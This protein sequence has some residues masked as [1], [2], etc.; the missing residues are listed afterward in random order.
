LQIVKRVGVLSAGKVFGA[1]YFC[2]GLLVIPMFFL[3]AGMAVL[4][5]QNQDKAAGAFG[6]GMMVVMAVLAP[7]I[8]GVMGFIAGMLMALLYNFLTR[9][10]GG[11]ELEFAPAVRETPTVPV[12]VPQV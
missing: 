8:Y 12:P 6:A 10:I 1:M 9:F 5:A 4:G 7:V 3:I 11:L 2:F